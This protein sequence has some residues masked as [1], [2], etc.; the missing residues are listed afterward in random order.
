[1]RSDAFITVSCDKCGDGK[2]YELCAIACNGWDE[3]GID[4]A[5][6]RDGWITDGD[7]DICESC[8]DGGA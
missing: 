7:Q 2:N 6:K 8:Q 3:R 1:M 4:K 5:L